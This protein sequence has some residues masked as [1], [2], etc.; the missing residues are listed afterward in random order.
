[1]D[2][3]ITVKKLYKGPAPSRA[4]KSCLDRMNVGGFEYITFENP[5]EGA[6][7]IA[8]KS[9]VEKLA[10]NKRYR[11]QEGEVVK[12]GTTLPVDEV[13]FELDAQNVDELE[14]KEGFG[15]EGT[16]VSRSDLNVLSEVLYNQDFDCSIFW[17]KGAE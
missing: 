5:W 16:K 8:R 9:Y 15:K 14:I 2:T 13:L 11:A 10:T 1:M 6:R 12:L 4:P 17:A 7:F 3:K